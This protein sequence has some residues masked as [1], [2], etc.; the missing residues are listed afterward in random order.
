MTYCFDS[1]PRVTNRQESRLAT[2]E[3]SPKGEGPGPIYAPAKSAFPPSLAVRWP[4]IT[5]GHRP[6]SAPVLPE[7]AAF[8]LQAPDDDLL[9]RFTASRVIKLSITAPAKSAFPPSLAVRW[10]V[11]KAGHRPGRAPRPG[12]RPRATIK[13][14]S[15]PHRGGSFLC[16]WKTGDRSGTRASGGAARGHSGRNLA[17]PGPPATGNRPLDPVLMHIKKILR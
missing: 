17:F 10:A 7:S 11:V 4:L 9:F 2:T 14:G 1:R 12:L 13:K 3:G 16:K 5:V 8:Y 6:R 15:F